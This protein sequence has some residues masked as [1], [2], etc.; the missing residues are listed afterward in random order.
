[1]S[2]GQKQRLA[3]ARAWLRQPNW[4]VLDD[5]LSALD[6]GTEDTLMSKVLNAKGERGIILI[7]LKIKPLVQAH[8]I[9]VLEDGRLIQQGTHDELLHSCPLYLRM[10]ELQQQSPQDLVTEFP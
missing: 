9:Y 2:G 4:M 8:R 5:A 10:F 3:L 1:L 7:S 6:G